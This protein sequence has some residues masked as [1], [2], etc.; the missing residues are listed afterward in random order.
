MVFV[1]SITGFG[2]NV[3]MMA[4]LP[5][6]LPT[7]TSSAVADFSGFLTALLLGWKYFRKAN[8]RIL[9]VPL[10]FFLAVS[11]LCVFLSISA[12]DDLLRRGLGIILLLLS[13]YFFFFQQKARLRPTFLSGMAM[14]ILSGITGGLFA[15]AGPPFV[16]Y[17]LSCIEDHEE[18]MGTIEF[19]FI[20]VSSFTFLLRL[21]GGAFSA[22]LMMMNAVTLCA[23]A[24]ALPLGTK[25]VK[26]LNPTVIRRLVYLFMA[27]T[28]L[29]MCVQP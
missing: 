24:L 20:I 15:M 6:F 23:L 27:V 4:I 21:F 19:Y 17:A 13:L 8:F 22:E 26:K 28:G 10:C 12:P 1:Q 25:V 2:S 29:W 14:G 16:L 11:A 3:V 5:S 7:F 9:I 18:Y